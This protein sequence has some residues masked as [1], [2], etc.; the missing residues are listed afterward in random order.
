M[1]GSLSDYL[2]KKLQDHVFGAT[3]FTAPATVY[4]ALLTDS[5]T[6]AQRDA[7][8]VTEVTGGAYARVAVTNNTT[9]FP[10]ASGV[11]ALKNLGVAFSFPA[12][13][14]NW[15]TATAFAIYDAATVGNLLCWGDLTTPRVINNGDGAP[16]FAINALNGTLD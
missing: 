15:G 4:L 8:T 7:G 14:A 16:S 12:P 2:E 10:A 1:A 3:V 13:T 9:N 11:T 5:N 6:A